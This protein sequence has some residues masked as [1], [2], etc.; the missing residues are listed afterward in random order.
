VI[1]DAKQE[2][3]KPVPILGGEAGGALEVMQFKT[4]MKMNALDRHLP[5]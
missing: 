5:K 4:L 1:R 2:R 3:E